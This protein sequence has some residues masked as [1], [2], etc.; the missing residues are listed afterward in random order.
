MGDL[1]PT[2]HS[3]SVRGWNI[4]HNI[5]LWK[6]NF[7]FFCHQ[8][9][10]TLP[11][12][13]RIWATNVV[14]D[15]SEGNRALTVSKQFQMSALPPLL[16]QS[17]GEIFHLFCVKYFTVQPIGNTSSKLDDSAAPASLSQLSLIQRERE[18][19]QSIIFRQMDWAPDS[20]LHWEN[21]T[22]PC[23]PFSPLSHHNQSDKSPEDS[24]TPKSHPIMY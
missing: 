2:T 24:P 10:S 3:L 16:L 19:L 6:L 17:E 5:S 14:G 9:W 22:S 20:S 18:R 1:C 12:C 7:C 8:A 15:E 13:P 4:L 23:P 11:N 21:V